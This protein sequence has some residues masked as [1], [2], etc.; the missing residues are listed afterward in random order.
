MSGVERCALPISDSSKPGTSVAV[1]DMNTKKQL[2]AIGFQGA[3]A[4]GSGLAIDE[5]SG[6]FFVTI[7]DNN[8]VGVG[9]LETL[10][11]LGFFKAKGCP[12]A[13]KV[14]T[15]R[16]LG[17]V[18]NASDGWLTVFDLKELKKVLGM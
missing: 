9:S 11:P 4:P 13:V 7:G 8:A 10:K 3:N 6:L 15:A 16:G 18:S 5:V 2:A 12:Y 14:D 1:F 17:F